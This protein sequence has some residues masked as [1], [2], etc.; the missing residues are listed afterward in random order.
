[1]TEGLNKIPRISNLKLWFTQF[2]E[3]VINLVN[4]LSWQVLLN[5]LLPARKL[6]FQMISQKGRHVLH[7]VPLIL[8]PKILGTPGRKFHKAL[9]PSIPSKLR[10]LSLKEPIH[11]AYQFQIIPIQLLY[12]KKVLILVRFSSSTYPGH[13]SRAS[14]RRM[15]LWPWA[16]SW[17]TWRWIFVERGTSGWFS[18]ERLWG[19]IG[20]TVRI[21]IGVV[22][23][24]IGGSS[25]RGWWSRR[26]R[27]GI[28]SSSRVWKEFFIISI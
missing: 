9:K 26:L 16:V 4:K 13:C 10:A 28:I 27:A 19:R 3:K 23:L 1:M 25:V 11:P 15:R 2:Q 7:L 14:T 24:T 20:L 21:S 18:R 5:I 8:I 17:M 12:S 22:R 6:Q